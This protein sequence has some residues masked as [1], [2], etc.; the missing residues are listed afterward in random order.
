MRSSCATGGEVAPPEDGALVVVAT[1][2]GNLGDLSPRAVLA[3]TEAAVICCEDTRRT[4]ALLTACGLR[5]G[6]RLRSLHRHNEGD[7]I[8]EI[9]RLLD[10]QVT[11]AVVSDAGTPGISDPGARLVA[12]AADAGHQV[13]TVPGPSAVLAALVVSGLPTDRFAMEGFLPR[14]GSARRQ[15]LSAVAADARTTVVLEAP[16]RLAA[17]LAD[18][19]AACGDRR[20]VV[21]RELTKVHEEVWRGTLSSLARR[22]GDDEVRGEV[23]I[24]LAGAEQPSPASDEE[25]VTLVRDELALGKGVRDAAAEVA[26]AAGVGRRRVYQLALQV[27]S[28]AP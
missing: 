27:A 26:T 7:R 2:I 21:A 6:S 28:E 10:D 15:R 14:K 22:A 5:A 9:L 18:L 1:P 4:R 23:V 16:V 25:L 8:P 11:V 12:A 19:M 17:T 20:A 3:L 24:V 13:R